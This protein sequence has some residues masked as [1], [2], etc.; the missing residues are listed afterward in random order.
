[1]THVAEQMRAVGNVS[2]EG[3]REAVESGQPNIVMIAAMD[4]N[5]VIGC[6]NQI[7]WRLPA[8]QQVFRHL[9]MGHTLLTGRLN[10][11]AMGRP[12]PGRRTVVMTRDSRYSA[13]GCELVH[14]IGEAVAK[15]GRDEQAP[16]FVIGG[17]QLYRMFLPLAHTLYL[18]RIQA[19][20]EGDTYF[21]RINETVWR[22]IWREPGLVDEANI[23]PHTYTVYRR[24]TAVQD[25]NS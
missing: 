9:T 23:Y 16:L 8:D 14:E 18:T 5:R 6:R 15:Y 25:G 17:E 4:R 19:E 21:P 12:L 7:P 24:Q 13:P 10:F 2:P 22:E 3:K 11:E 1:M 20:F